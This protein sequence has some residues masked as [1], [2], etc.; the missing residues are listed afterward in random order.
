ME[1]GPHGKANFTWSMIGAICES[2]LNFVL[3]IVVNRLAGEVAGGVFTFAFSHAQLMYY[4][5]TLEVRPI[6]STDVNTFPCG[7][8]PAQG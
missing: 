6:Q 7:Q 4:L 1:L 3:L 2:A 8:F 5:G